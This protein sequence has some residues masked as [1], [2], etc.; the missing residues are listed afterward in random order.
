M[1]EDKHFRAG[2]K[3]RQPEAY[4][5]FIPAPL[6]PSPP[7][8][9]SYEILDLLSKADRALGRLDGSTSMLPNPNLFVFMYVRKEAVLSSQIEGTQASLTDLL[10]FEANAREGIPADVV[11]ISNYI[12]ATNYGL[13]RL[14]EFPLSLRLLKE[15]HA[16]L[17][18]D[19]R[20]STKTPGEFRRTQ[21]WIGAP[22]CDLNNA[23]F[24]PPPPQEM[25]KALG[26]WELF[27][28]NDSPIPLLIKLGLIH[29]QFETIHP[30]LDGNGRVGRLLITFLLCQQKVLQRPLLYL[31]IFFKRKRTEYYDRLQAIRDN[32]DWEAW[33]RFFL[34]GVYEAAQ[35]AT[36]TAR[37]IVLL[38]ER[39]R[40]L[41]LE[42]A[43]GKAPNAL[44]LLE[45][46]YQM[47]F[48]SVSQIAKRL[49]ITFASANTLAKELEEAEILLE[50]T[51]QKRNRMFCYEAYL[52][53]FEK[54]TPVQP[55]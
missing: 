28:H 33:I 24:V 46:L 35:E 34:Q 27:L 15:I 31:S 26:E 5:A 14:E 8:E 12:T 52:D 30:F 10:A 18:E 16:K 2:Q 19:T 9:M 23:T 32:G 39:H 3:I 11:E 41:I 38:R 25:M 36:E 7:L 22:G 20:G 1:V 48:F 55:L 50:T 21:N 47:P 44:K 17:L 13:K 37:R 54:D 4:H 40:E 42:K 6:P 53:L 29:A 43:G 45:I 49:E 51:G